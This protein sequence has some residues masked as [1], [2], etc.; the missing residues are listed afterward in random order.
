MCSKPFEIT[1]GNYIIAV[2]EYSSIL[3]EMHFVSNC[4]YSKMLLIDD[5][6]SEFQSPY[7][8]RIK[9]KVDI[10]LCRD[11]VEI[12][13]DFEIDKEFLSFV[14]F[15]IIKKRSLQIDK[16][17]TDILKQYGYESLLSLP[18]CSI[19]KKKK[20]DEYDVST[21]TTVYNNAK[22][23][24]QTIQSVI[25]QDYGRGRHQFVIKDAKSTDNIIEIVEKYHDYIDIFVSTKDNGIYFGM[26]EAVDYAKGH[27]IHFL[28]SDDCFASKDALSRM[29]PFEKNKY[30]ANYGQILLYSDN[31]IVEKS[32]YDIKDLYKYCAVGHPAL[33]TS[34][35]VFCEIGGFNTA[36]KI[37]A[38]SFMTIQ[39]Y[40]WGVNFKK[41]NDICILFRSSGASA[42]QKWTR[43]K[44]DLKCRIAYHPLNIL[45]VIITIYR[46]LF[47]TR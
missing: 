25:N 5:S 30:V 33:F 29:A 34:K 28:N 43:I 15:E 40:K 42:Q 17:I 23:L 32:N 18:L 38:D 3:Y 20:N 7:V 6:W 31:G 47:I 10:Y 1:L 16:E 11:G 4:D 13:D 44:E 8:S 9:E 26:N 37:S 21:L 39:M 14:P 19:E 22:L 41:H 12:V 36:F 27:T 35:S 24:E 2:Y 45:G 46:A